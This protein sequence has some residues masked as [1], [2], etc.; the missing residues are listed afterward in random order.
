MGLDPELEFQT[1]SFFLGVIAV[2]APEG[3][4]QNAR[5]STTHATI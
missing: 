1:G 2:I 3:A 5:A 4:G